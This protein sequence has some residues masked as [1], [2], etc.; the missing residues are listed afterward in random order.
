M[1]ENQDPHRTDGIKKSPLDADCAATCSR[2]LLPPSPPAEKITARQ[3]QAEQTSTD[4]GAWNRHRVH[5]VA[6]DAF[7][8]A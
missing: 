4:D 3:D 7:F 6:E 1:S 8:V 2:N 5:G